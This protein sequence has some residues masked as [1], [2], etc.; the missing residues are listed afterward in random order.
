VNVF[1]TK[2]KINEK[3]TSLSNENDNDRRTMKHRNTA[4][5]IALPTPLVTK[6]KKKHEPLFLFSS[7]QREFL[8]EL[9]DEQPLLIARRKVY[10]TD[11]PDRPYT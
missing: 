4:E 5:L 10:L 11:K 3:P 6:K 9:C 8:T 7:C 2:T 1:Y